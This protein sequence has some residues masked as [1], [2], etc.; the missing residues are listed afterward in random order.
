MATLSQFKCIN[1]SH[2]FD[3]N[4]IRYRCDCGDLLEVIHDLN[5][6]IP[7]PEKWKNSLE[8]I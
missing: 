5:S 6:S 1:C 3:I 7:Y 8:I 2:E 4:E